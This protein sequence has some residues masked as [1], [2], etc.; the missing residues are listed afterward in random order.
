[1]RVREFFFKNKKRFKQK[2]AEYVYLVDTWR[3]MYATRRRKHMKYRFTEY[4]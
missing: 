2:E 4:S 3:F 1:M